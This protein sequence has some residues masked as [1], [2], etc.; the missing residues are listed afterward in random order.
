MK[1]NFQNLTVSAIALSFLASAFPAEAKLSSN[2][3]RAVVLEAFY[4]LRPSADGSCDHAISGNCVSSWNYLI[5]DYSAYQKLMSW[6]GCKFASV[7]EKKQDCGVESGRPYSYYSDPY[8][9]GIASNI[10]R[11]GQC[12]H[13]A[14]LILYRS[15]AHTKS[16]NSLYSSSQTINLDSQSNL[17]SVKEGDVIFKKGDHTAIVVEIK[18]NK[19]GTV[20]GLDVIDSNYVGGKGSEIIGR[21]LFSSADLANGYKVWTGSDYYKSNYDPR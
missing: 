14:N 5:N 10:G 21:H 2:T 9:Y 18:K 6:Y 12:L 13:F 7:W 8:N 20:T 17:K 16:F 1:A 11:G 15:G 4:A 19:N 3:R